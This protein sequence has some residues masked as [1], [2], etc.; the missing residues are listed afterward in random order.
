MSVSERH[1]GHA[2]RGRWYTAGGGLLLSSGA[3]GV[4]WPTAFFHGYLVATL[5]WV[6]LPL[7]AMALLMT[8]RL[9]GGRWGWSFQ[10]LAGAMASMLPWGIVLIVPVLLGM[11]FLYPW[12]GAGSTT[13]GAHAGFRNLYLNEGF[14]ATR[15]IGYFL[16]WWAMVWPLIGYGPRAALWR[17]SGR[18]TP[19]AAAVGLL[20][21]VM[22][23]TFAGIDWVA[24]LE[25]QWYSS[26]FGLYVLVGQVLTAFAGLLVV[27]GVTMQRLPEAL[28]ASRL[29]DLGNLL[30]TLVILHAYLGFSQ[31]FIIW[32]GNLPHETSWFARRLDSGWGAFALVLIAL[33]FGLPF[34][35]LLFRHVKQHEAFLL[36][37]A[38]VILAGR[39]LDNIW[40]VLPAVEEEKLTVALLLTMLTIV[41]LGCLT[42]GTISGNW[43]KR[44]ARMARV[45]W[46]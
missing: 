36:P 15:S 1:P 41:G 40:M 14:F 29:H 20:V 6:S 37:L 10:P 17:A 23:V 11:T 35:A 16:V 30:L 42:S 3:I 5:F 2:R 43:E 24:S 44:L 31:F 8:H 27:S 22:T 13:G 7:G 32:N 26:I 45:V 34:F 12:A 46:R 18:M 38:V 33:H 4:A 9:T 39:L 19:R 28:R 25:A 21:Y